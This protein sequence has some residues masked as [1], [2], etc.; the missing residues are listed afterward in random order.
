MSTGPVRYQDLIGLWQEGQR[1]L[2]AADG[3]ER[4][5]MERVVDEL[6]VNFAGGWAARSPSTSLRAVHRPGHRLVL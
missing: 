6:V 5:A 1:R 2:A 3:S 4:A